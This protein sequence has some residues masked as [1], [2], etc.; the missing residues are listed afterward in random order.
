[1]KIEFCCEEMQ[2]SLWERTFLV[3]AMGDGIVGAQGEDLSVCPFCG[4]EIEVGMAEPEG[5]PEKKKDY[6]WGKNWLADQMALSRGE[7]KGGDDG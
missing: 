3:T 4:A 6:Q 2:D 1:M 5:K 7:F